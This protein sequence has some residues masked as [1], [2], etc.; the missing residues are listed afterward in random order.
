MVDKFHHIQFSLQICI[1][2]QTCV[3]QII[4]ISLCVCPFR[5]QGTTKKAFTTNLVRIIL[6]N[7]QSYTKMWWHIIG[8]QMDYHQNLLMKVLIGVLVMKIKVKTINLTFLF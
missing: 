6:A 4:L 1:V 5:I 3:F 2:L 7:Q 8:V